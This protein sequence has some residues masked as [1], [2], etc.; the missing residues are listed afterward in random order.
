MSK[1]VFVKNKR[2]GEKIKMKTAYGEYE[3]PLLEGKMHGYGIFRWDD[4]KIYKG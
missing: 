2:I 4:G 3:G 1:G